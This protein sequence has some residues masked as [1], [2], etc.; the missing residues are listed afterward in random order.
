[1]LKK[2]SQGVIVA[3]FLAIPATI[4]AENA[5]APKSTKVEI[6]KASLE[7]A[8]KLVNEM[9]MSNSYQE[10]INRLTDNLIQRFPKLN[11]VKDK[12]LD[13]YKKYLGW[14][15]IKDDVAK[16]YAKHFTAKEI[17]DLLTFYKSPT[18]K[19]ALKE[20]PAITME[21]REIG[22]RKVASHI[23]EL[24]S[25]IKSALQPQN[26]NTAPKK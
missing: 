11:S 26:A 25:I 1:M 3:V 6:D 10:T 9:E 23:G 21:A 12:I 24:E 2:I 20:L 15:K 18:G 4:S 17:E 7:A 5:T 13:F 22:M 14:D 16:V 19:K 8:K